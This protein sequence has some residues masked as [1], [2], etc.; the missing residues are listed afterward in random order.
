MTGEPTDL[1]KIKKIVSVAFI[2]QCLTA[3]AKAE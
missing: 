2:E 1:G 3:R